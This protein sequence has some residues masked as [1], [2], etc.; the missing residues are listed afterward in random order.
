MK[1]RS[2]LAVLLVMCLLAA[3]L[4]VFVP[5]AEAQTTLSDND[6]DG[7]LDIENVFDLQAMENDLWAKYELV[8][9]INASVTKDWNGGAGFKPIGTAW[10]DPF[11]GCLEG[12]NKI[13]TDLYI[14]RPTEYY[15]GLFSYFGWYELEWPDGRHI[16]NLT[17]E[18][19]HITGRRNVGALAGTFICESEGDPTTGPLRITNVHVVGGSI[20]G[21]SNVAGLVGGSAEAYGDF[22]I[23]GCSNS[24]TIRALGSLYNAGGLFGYLICPLIENCWNTGSVTGYRAG[25]IAGLMMANMKNCYNQGHIH[26]I[27]YEGGG[28]VGYMGPSWPDT[29]TYVQDSWNSG[30]ITGEDSSYIGGCFGTTFSRLTYMKHLV[31]ERCWNTGTVTGD[32]D[33]WCAGG[34][35]GENYEDAWIRDCYSRGN[36]TGGETASGFICDQYGDGDGTDGYNLIERCYST[37]TVSTVDPAGRTGGFTT[38]TDSDGII[39]TN[40]F[41]DVETSGETWSADGTGQ[42]TADMKTQSTFTGAG[43]DFNTV[44]D[45]NGVTNDGYPFFPPLSGNRPPNQPEVVRPPNYYNFQL[46]DYLTL[47]SSHFSDPDGDNFGGAEWEITE[48]S[49]DYTNPM[50]QHYSTYISGWLPTIGVPSSVFEPYTTYFWHVR[51]QDEHG[52]YSGWSP[53][54]QFYTGIER[55]VVMVH[56]YTSPMP[57]DKVN[58]GIWA[59]LALFLTHPDEPIDELIGYLSERINSKIDEKSPI[60]AY[61]GEGITSYVSNYTLNPG[62]RVINLPPLPPLTIGGTSRDINVYA[63]E[64][65]REIQR[66]KEEQGVSE[67][68]VVAHSM[69]G[70]VARAYIESSDFDGPNDGGYYHDDI[71]RLIMIATPNNGSEWYK[72]L[73]LAC[74]YWQPYCQEIIGE[75]T[76]LGSYPVAQIYPHS[77][78]LN[79]LNAGVSGEDMG[80]D[81]YTLAGTRWVNSVLSWLTG[82]FDGMVSVGDVKL[83]GIPLW[84]EDASHGDLPSSPGVMKIAGH[85]LREQWDQ[86][87]IPDEDP[88]AQQAPMISGVIYTG[89]E[90]THEV[91]IGNAS[92]AML[93]LD[94]LD[95]QLRLTL[96]T[97][98]GQ[99][100]DPSVA[101]ADPSIMHMQFTDDLTVGEVYGIKDP[102]PGIWIV[103]VNAVEAPDYGE[104]YAVSTFLATDTAITLALDKHHYTPGETVTIAAE[105]TNE[106]EEITNPSV[107]ASIYRLGYTSES[108]EL[109]DDGVHNDGEAGDGLFANEYL[110]TSSQGMY[111]IAVTASGSVNGIYFELQDRTAVW[112]LYYPDLSI[113]ASDI[114]F[115]DDN[116]VGGQNVTISAAVHNIGE[117]NVENAIIDFYDGPPRYDDLLGEVEL[118]VPAGGSAQATVT[119]EATAG[120][121]EIYVGISPYNAFSES[122]YSNNGVFKSIHVTGPAVVADAGGPYVVDEGYPVVFNASLSSDPG[123]AP[124]LYRWDFDS[125]GS[126]DMGWVNCSIGATVWV[127]NGSRSVTVEVSNGVLSGRDTASVIVNNVAP[128]VEIVAEMQTPGDSHVMF[129]GSNFIDPGIEDT[130]TIEWDFGDGEGTTGILSPTHAYNG[131]GDY[132]VTLTVTDDDGGIGTDTLTVSVNTVSDIPVSVNDDYS[133]NEDTIPEVAAPGVLANDSDV[134]PTAVL[135]GDVSNGDLTLNSDG[136]FTYTP[137]ADFN[138]SDTF[139]Y[140]AVAG[141]A[142]SDVATVTI[143]VNPVNDAPTVVAGSDQI[144]DEGDMVAFSGSYTD[145]D[146][147]SFRIVWDFGDGEYAAG[148]LSPTHVYIE[149]GLYTVT[150]IVQDSDGSLGW[151]TLTVT[152]NDLVPAAAFTWSPEPQDEGSPVQFVDASTWSSDEIVAWDWDFGGYGTST[153][154]NTSFTFMDDGPFDVCLTVTDD[155]GSTDTIYQTVATCNVAPVL[156]NITAPM[157]PVEVG[158]PITASANFSDAGTL[159]THTALWNWGGNTTSAGIVTETDGFGSVTGNQTYDEAGVYTLMLTL[160]DD[161]GGLVTS[162]FQYIVVYDPE[163]GFV[164]GGGWINSPEGAYATDP[165]LIGKAN[166]GF[167]SKYKHGATTPTGNTEFRFKAGDLNFHSSNYDWLVVANFKAMYKGTGT[168][169]GEGNY[170]FMLTAIDEELT[171]STDVD[172]FRI[173]IWDKYNEDAI[174][175]D[176][177]M[178]AED[179]EDPTTEIQGGNIIVHD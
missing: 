148:T 106:T 63:G 36:V 41:W 160:E 109:Y 167:V 82:D 171:P 77:D 79:L 139:T 56:G 55:A 29:Y 123:G 107:N 51:Y 120:D 136:S 40:N 92:E 73:D 170:G 50:F 11:R 144:I 15:I 27:G 18:N 52:L 159:D 19:P 84:K 14:Y 104:A 58:P 112:A 49:N 87:P 38:E 3:S 166:F 143:T 178:G 164:T 76:K 116:P 80:V 88:T 163:G 25:G 133:I 7:Y 64:L 62:P 96:V 125:N 108:L 61:E 126:W 1:V 47:V 70:L 132:T 169:N 154:Q 13:I 74:F 177:Q 65:G 66:V 35:A 129:K 100:I 91:V 115:S 157:D 17:F 89:E 101:E 90:Q 67:V 95:G 22:K 174:V 172:L 103:K 111:N 124:L 141:A 137:D 72:L 128:A 134:E 37:G 162:E 118:T 42:T 130:H 105:L 6:G 145:P 152:V 138:G 68:Y 135:V 131:T 8:N 20:D 150:L 39:R 21:D 86:L 113:T 179:D 173:K 168:V 59:A 147:D 176:N 110:N 5:T 119:W 75:L 140:K 153:S 165:T 4:P 97:P 60:W 117:A 85:I 121:H 69:G 98:S 149:D 175:Y 102:E 155:D 16:S 127:D 32:S 24:A 93:Q 53:E 48:T 146:S 99:G 78:F 94:S 9:N 31:I 12:N 28:L 44:W 156:G 10:S 71:G 57:W 45:I 33:S 122:D 2:G 114:S 151:D 142:E 81:Y 34:F 46:T 83:D 30:E 23:S 161:D 26:C 54:R 158:T 43:W